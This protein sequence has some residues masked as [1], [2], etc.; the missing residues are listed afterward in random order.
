MT[1]ILKEHP[2]FVTIMSGFSLGFIIGIAIGI[3]KHCM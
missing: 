1:D 2:W 3:A